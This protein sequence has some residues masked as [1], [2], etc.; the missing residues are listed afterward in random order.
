[1]PQSIPAFQAGCPGSNP[2]RCTSF[3]LSK[4]HPKLIAVLFES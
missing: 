4:I 1:M 3:I 2:G